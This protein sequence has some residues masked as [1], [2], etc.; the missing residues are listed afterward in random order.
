MAWGQGNGA[1]VGTYSKPIQ[2]ELTFPVI[3]TTTSSQLIQSHPDSG[4]P[5]TPPHRGNISG[6]HHGPSLH[7]NEQTACP[8]EAACTTEP[9]VWVPAPT[10]PIPIM[11]C[12]CL[13]QASSSPTFCISGLWPIDFDLFL[14]RIYQRLEGC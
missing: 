11:F 12:L 14:P 4:W 13:G 8:Q 10:A 7:L 1:V 3:P 6:T 5:H 9:L 2:S